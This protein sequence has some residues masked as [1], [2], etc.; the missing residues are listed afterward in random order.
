M[1]FPSAL[2][3]LVV[4][5][6]LVATTSCGHHPRPAA[7]AA[8]PAPNVTVVATARGSTLPVFTHPG[9]ARAAS[10]LSGRTSYGSPRAVDVLGQRGGWL[11]V[12]LPER[13]VGARGWVRAADVRLTRTTYRVEVSLSRRS[14]SVYDGSRVLLSVTAAVGAPGTPTPAGRFFVTDVVHVGSDQPAYGPYA[15]GLSGFS[16]TLTHFENGD[17]QVALHGTDQPQLL[18]QRVSHGCVR[19][20]NATVTVL[21]R[22]LPLG[23][24][25]IVRA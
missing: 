25:V 18:G 5:A 13:P 23:T 3:A 14:L 15:L 10:Q 20:A 11:L 9:D 12:L 2:S 4:V 22:T 7:P 6:A 17:G 8:G 16:P 21:A 1:R 19:L 24:P